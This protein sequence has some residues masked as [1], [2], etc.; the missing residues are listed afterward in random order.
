MRQK[1]DFIK[2]YIMN[3]SNV[4]KSKI[5]KSEIR[6]FCFIIYSSNILKK[7][8]ISRAALDKELDYVYVFAEML[9][10]LSVRANRYGA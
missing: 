2:V 9:G 3:A 10:K 1:K 5:N 4:L 6:Y 8:K 7:L